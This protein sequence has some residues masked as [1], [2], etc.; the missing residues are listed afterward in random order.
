[1]SSNVSFA[2]TKS[3][4]RFLTEHS[5]PGEYL[6]EEGVVSG[7]TVELIRILQQ[8]LDEP[9][10]IN[11]LPWGRAM[12][13]ARQ[14]AGLALFET[15][16]TEEREKWFKWVGPLQSYHI[17]L[18]GLKKQIQNKPDIKTSP[19]KY[20]ACAYRNSAI[21]AEIEILGFH[22]GKN[23]ILTNKVGDCQQMLLLGRADVTPVSELRVDDFITKAK[24]MGDKLVP[25]A[26]LTQRQRY[27]A[28]SLDVDT[29]RTTRWQQALEQSYLDGT[30]RQ[31]YQSVYSESIIQR[32]ED[33]AKK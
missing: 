28:F 11:I 8:R 33:M 12:K 26:F 19:Q 3:S 13:I 5:P 16:R 23:L 32:L 9:G 22:I 14:E 17:S 7:V 2:Q 1:V 6:N 18:Y 31:L 15:V 24:Q 29:K 27:L 25:V 30:M 4:L 20:I 21:I 10:E